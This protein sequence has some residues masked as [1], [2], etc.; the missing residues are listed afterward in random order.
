MIRRAQGSDWPHGRNIQQKRIVGQ[1]IQRVAGGPGKYTELIGSS[2]EIANSN[3]DLIGASIA[4]AVGGLVAE[5]FTTDEAAGR[6]IKQGIIET[7]PINGNRATD[8]IRL[9]ARDG[10][11]QQRPRQRIII[12]EHWQRVVGAVFPDIVRIRA[13]WQG[14]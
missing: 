5:S 10:Q 9:E 13:G 7:A 1:D 8:T 3:R 2:Y 11:S 12:F 14:R 4:T 6:R